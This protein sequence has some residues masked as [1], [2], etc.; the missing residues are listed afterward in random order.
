[1]SDA[2]GRPDEIAAGASNEAATNFTLGQLSGLL[3]VQHQQILTQVSQTVSTQIKELEETL[4]ASN[5][6][7]AQAVVRESA[8]DPY[9]LKRKGNK[10]QSDFN[11]KIFNKQEQALTAL[12][13]KQYE[14]AKRELEEGTQL[15]AKAIR[16]VIYIDDGIGEAGTFENAVII[17]QQVKSDLVACGFTLNKV[18]WDAYTAITLVGSYFKFQNRNYC[19]H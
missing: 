17:S 16:V 6:E 3:A 4:R 12:K 2:D 9:V 10:F 1:M 8:N 14:K 19:H 11:K 5:T 7:L 13:A 15:I 18:C